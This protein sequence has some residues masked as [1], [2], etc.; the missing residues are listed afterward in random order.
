MPRNLT[1]LM[2]A[3]VSSAPPEPHLA[4]DI[5]RLA[6]RN[7]RR[8]TAFVAGATA[9]AVIVVAGGAFGLTR[10]HATAPEPADSFLHD[11][12]V[13]ASQAVAASSL[14]GYQLEPWTIPSV[15]RLGGGLAPATTYRDV[16]A[17]G[18]LLTQSYAVAGSEVSVRGTD[19]YD[20]PGQN[21]TEVSSPAAGTWVPTFLDDGRLLWTQG[22]LHG[23]SRPG[24]YVSDLDGGHPVLVPSDV[25]L[26]A[27][28]Q[29][30]VTPMV[31]G[32]NFWFTV[33]TDSL[34]AEGGTEFALYRS[35]FSG[36]VTKVADHVATAT[37]NGGVV[38]WVT[39]KGQVVTQS[40]AGGAPHTVPVDLP[41]GCHTPSVPD[42]QNTSDGYLAVDSRVIALGVRCGS[43][44][45]GFDQ[46]VAFDLD[47]HPLMHVTGALGLDPAL[48]QESLVFEALVAPGFKEFVTLRYDFA[49]GSLVSLGTP[50]TNQPIQAPRAAGDHVLWYDGKGGHVADF[51]R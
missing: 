38:A 2:E 4:T 33:F 8:R 37:V 17:D 43:T 39:T 12:T 11:Q 29:T 22:S 42:I 19:L 10:G 14:P 15:Q 36:D 28:T 30:Q 51:G 25:Q 48:G 6:E 47:G 3:A 50:T 7:Q 16:D 46:M 9:V 45:N 5:T 23:I 26:D 49:T 31:S 41:T 27:H 21:P 32:D 13:D 24:S 1:D 35:T 40:S 44:K 20:A 18:R 34:S